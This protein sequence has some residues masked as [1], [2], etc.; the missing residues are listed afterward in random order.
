MAIIGLADTTFARY[1]MAKIAI[2]EI[3][4]NSSHEIVRYTV[5]GFKDLPVAAKKLIQEQKCDIVIAMGMAG[6]AD[7]DA[8]CAHEASIGLI[9]A[10]LMTNTHILGV[11]VHGFEAK[12]DQELREIMID[13][14]RKHAKNAIALLEGKMSLTSQAGKGLRQGFAN[15]GSIE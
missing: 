2:K 9:Q 1:D 7:I 4:N 12:T 6:N 14:T 11:F 10:Q 15:E 13:R 3:Q 5:P 8:Q